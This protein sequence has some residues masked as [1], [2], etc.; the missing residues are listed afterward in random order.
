M[1]TLLLGVDFMYDK[2]GNLIPIEI[3]TNVGWDG[4][5]VI[6]NSSALNEDYSEIVDL[7]ELEAFITEQSFNK[8]VYIGIVPAVSSGLSKI[9]IKLG[10]EYH[11]EKLGSGGITV[12][13]IEDNDTTLIIRSAYDTT[14]LVDETYC[15]D[16]INYLSLIKNEQFGTQF[17]YVDN[18]STLINTIIT[19]VDN[20]NHPNFILKY[21]YPSYDK[22]VY[23]K[24]FKATTQEQLNTIIQNN[25][26]S[27]YFLTPFYLNE[28]KLYQGNITVTRVLSLLIPP[29]LTSITLGSYAKSSDLSILGLTPTFNSSTFE[30]DQ[31]LRGAYLVQGNNFASPKLSDDDFIEMADGTFK[32]AE[33]LQIGDEVL[34][35]DIPNPTNTDLV[36]EFAN[37]H[38]DYDTLVSGSSYST[39]RITNKVRVNRLT[40]VVKITFTDSTDWYDTANSSYLTDVDGDIKYTQIKKLSKG[41]I[42]VLVNSNNT[43]SVDYVQKTIDTVETVKEMFSGWDITVE[44][45]HMFLTV[46]QPE[47]LTTDPSQKPTSYVAIEHNNIPCPYTTQCVSNSPQCPKAA[48]T[49]YYG[50]CK[51][52]FC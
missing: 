27:D 26:T 40:E 39:N 5:G 34:T 33:A 30:L 6:E 13:F 4:T 44:N 19:L 9:A 46:S 45:Q 7:S 23:P 42:L 51:A 37:F 36:N 18:T 49:C 31:E 52:T 41:D 14:A 2:D 28:S 24:L 17:A 38:I 20:G 21:R 48:P 3:N 10:L 8:V 29:A 16:K 43:S 12:P 47:L 35:I 11:Q 32:T 22:K 25:V 1:R 15:R 50:V